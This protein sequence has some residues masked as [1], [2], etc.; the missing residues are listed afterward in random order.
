MLRLAWRLAKA[1]RAVVRALVT[2]PREAATALNADR[3]HLGRAMLLILPAALFIAVALPQVTLVVT[4]SIGAWI[5][6]RAPGPI[7]KGDLVMFTLSHPV[8]GPKPVSVTK[9]ALCLPG[10]RLTMIETPSRVAPREWDGHFYCNDELLGV[11][12]THATNGLKLQHFRWNGVIPAGHIYV[13]SHH[14]RGFDS[15][16]FGLMP[17]DRLTRMARL[18]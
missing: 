6:R 13:G 17:I 1:L 7:T 8:A 18:L 2:L 10:E 9:Y 12:L 5:V 11:S 4:P 15:R 3:R 14:V 16:Y